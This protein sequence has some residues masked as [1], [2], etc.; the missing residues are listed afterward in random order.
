MSLLQKEI[1][2][3]SKKW[4]WLKW[5]LEE[6]SSREFSILCFADETLNEIVRRIL[7]EAEMA[8]L[9][10]WPA[11]FFEPETVLSHWKVLLLSATPPKE[12]PLDQTPAQLGLKD[13]DLILVRPASH[14][15]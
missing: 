5:K 15:Q 9:I 10:N 11:V 13:G 12:L 2:E 8:D 3:I 7:V 1:I 4:L 14:L 6:S